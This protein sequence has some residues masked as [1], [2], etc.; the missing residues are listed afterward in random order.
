MLEYWDAGKQGKKLFVNGYLLLGRSA[1]GAE[2]GRKGRRSYVGG[3][4]EGMI[5]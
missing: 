2:R 1:L 4:N 3:Q 5:G